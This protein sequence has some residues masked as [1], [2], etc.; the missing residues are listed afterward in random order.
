MATHAVL[1]EVKIPE[2]SMVDEEAPT[3]RD[4]LDLVPKPRSQTSRIMD[5]MHIEVSGDAYCKID[6]LEAQ[7]RTL[8]S[9][10]RENRAELKVA[11]AQVA[12]WTR[13]YDASM[14]ELIVLRAKVDAAKPKKRRR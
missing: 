5:R 1:N 14:A 3:G 10:I 2:R 11:W 7:L 9:V 4:V 13:R 8:G 6:A 12:D